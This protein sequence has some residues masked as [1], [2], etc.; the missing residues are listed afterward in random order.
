MKSCVIQS[1]SSVDARFALPDGAGTDAIHTSPEYCMALTRL[2]SDGQISGTGIALTLG[3]GN[4]L[5]CEAI[6]LLAQPL[7]GLE[8]NR[9]MSDFGKVSR[10]LPARACLRM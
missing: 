7:A 8:I 10:P 2:A 9:I 5:V 4:R 3:D 6:D 1:V